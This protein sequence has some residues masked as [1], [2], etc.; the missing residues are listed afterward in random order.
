MSKF[1]GFVDY[2]SPAKTAGK[3]VRPLG[4][5]PDQ[6]KHDLVEVANKDEESVM[7]ST[8]VAGTDESS[9]VDKIAESVGL[10]DAEEEAS[11]NPK[12][13]PED[14]VQEVNLAEEIEKNTE[15]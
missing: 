1:K 5:L 9:D 13:E 7:G 2:Q 14:P 12:D 8:P 6:E 3:K 10:Y 4:V 15:K 11:D